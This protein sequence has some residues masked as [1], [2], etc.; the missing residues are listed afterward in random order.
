[1]ADKPIL[2]IMYDFDR[3]LSP[4]DM[5]EYAFIPGIDMTPGE[6]WGKCSEIERQ[7]QMDQILAYM[8]VMH[9]EAEGRLLITRDILRKLGKD[10][11][12]FP[13]VESWF[14]RV[15][16]LCSVTSVTPLL[17][18]NKNWVLLV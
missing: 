18:R 5:Q 16:R 8:L 7:N 10:V 4:K 9:R 12:L 14:E 1:M 3:T 2:A 15:K 17:M 11:E 6:F 13:G